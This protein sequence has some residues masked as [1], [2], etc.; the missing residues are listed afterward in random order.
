MGPNWSEIASL[1]AAVATPAASTDTTL[2]LVQQ[3]AAIVHRV[4]AEAQHTVARATDIAGRATELLEA[5]EKRIKAL[6]AAHSAAELNLREAQA[7][8]AD[9]EKSTGQS[10]AFLRGALS[11][12][13]RRAQ[14]AE[15]KV[16]ETIQSIQNAI[17]KELLGLGS[18]P[19]TP[20]AVAA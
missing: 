13:D 8:L 7:R 19:Q 12:A 9:F 5:A 14:N 20:L 16:E 1:S 11:D 3:A 4:K 17:R 18:Q 6:E 10:L 15:A 2:E